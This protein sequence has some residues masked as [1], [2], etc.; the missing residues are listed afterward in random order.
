[1]GLD[2]AGR[3]MVSYSL[4]KLNMLCDAECS[5]HVIIPVKFMEKGHPVL[6][7]LVATRLLHQLSAVIA[8]ENC[9]Y[10]LA[11][12][13]LKSIGRGKP[14]ESSTC[15]IFPVTFCCRTLIPKNG[16]I[17]TGTVHIVQK[18][19]VF[20][21]CGPMNQIYLSSQKMPNYQYVETENPFFLSNDM[22]RIEKNGVVCFSVFAVRWK[23]DKYRQFKILASIEGDS[24]GPVSL[25][26]TDVIECYEECLGSC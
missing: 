23:E 19:G 12:T 8:T 4:W 21:K 25:A 3:R 16:E 18:R 7:G 11:V 26:G 17:M 24:L 20:L 14:C 6:K 9:G 5:C 10:F 2:K 15:I 1:M 22:S 13:K